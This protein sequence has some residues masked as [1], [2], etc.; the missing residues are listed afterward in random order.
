MFGRIVTVSLAMLLFVALPTLGV[1]MDQVAE[2]SNCTNPR[3]SLHREL[4]LWDR[5]TGD[6]YLYSSKTP[7]DAPLIDIGK[8]IIVSFYPQGEVEFSHP[9][10]KAIKAH[11]DP[12]V[13]MGGILRLGVPSEEGGHYR[14][15]LNRR[16]WIDIVD[17]DQ[18]V[19]ASNFAMQHK[20]RSIIKT[21][22]FEL[23]G[24]REY[25]IQISSA[26]EDTFK[27]MVSRVVE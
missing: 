26:I 25:Y 8:K 23:E 6:H 27:V 15:S 19:F 9:P 24:G 12:S 11:K 4:T 7:G 17:G 1:D 13:W 3:M 5:D 18:L 2:M 21:V 22:E 14:V 20:C 16:A 10:E